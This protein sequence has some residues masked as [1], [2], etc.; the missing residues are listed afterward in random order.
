MPQEPAVL[1]VQDKAVAAMT[2][3]PVIV[4][5][6]GDPHPIALGQPTKVYIVFS[7]GDPVPITTC[8]TPELANEYAAALARLPSGHP[9]RTLDAQVDEIPLLRELPDPLRNPEA[10]T[11]PR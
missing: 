7:Y 9:L 3:E 10:Q 2:D 11:W 8:V 4:H 1:E 6:H 5:R